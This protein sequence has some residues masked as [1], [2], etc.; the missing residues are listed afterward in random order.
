MPW[1]RAGGIKLFLLPIITGFLSIMFFLIEQI[2]Q[3]QYVSI[4][5][6]AHKC[7]VKR[8]I[9]DLTLSVTIFTISSISFIF[10]IIIRAY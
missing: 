4:E 6:E 1:Q 10:I 8:N 3:V 9:Q 5:R 2:V 7:S